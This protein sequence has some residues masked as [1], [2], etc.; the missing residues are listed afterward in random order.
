MTK[1]FYTSVVRYGNKLLYRGYDDKGLATKERIPF[2]PTLFMSGESDEGWTTLDGLPMQPVVF[3]SMADAKDFNKRYENVSNFNIAGN[4]NYS[5]QFI[6]EEW[7]ERIDYDRSLIKTANIDIEVY[8]EEGFPQPEDAA[9]PITAITMRED[10]GTYWVWGCGEYTNTREDV[11]YIQ[12][13][14]EN[15]LIRK[16]VRRFEE[17]SPNIITGWILSLRKQLH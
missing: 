12:C 13:D 1:Q 11:L 17:Y 15:D 5:A 7:P 9:Y 16:F 10:T 4:T 6:A 14:N 2:K 3:D 8:S